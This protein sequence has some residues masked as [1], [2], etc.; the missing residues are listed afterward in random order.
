MF[1]DE[2]IG[3]LNQD[4]VTI[5]YAVDLDLPNGFV[6]THSG[7]GSLVINGF[8]YDGVGSFGSIGEAKSVGD[9]N[10]SSLTV[11]MIGIPSE[12]FVDVLS[13]HIRGSNVE[14]YMIIFDEFGRLDAVESLLFG[15]V[16]SYSLNLDSEGEIAIEVADEFNLYE[17]PLQLFCTN[18][19]WMTDH[20]GDE[21]WR[22]VAQ[23]SQRDIYWGNDIDAERFTV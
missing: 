6:R 10:P 4:G 12:F 3:K 18:E 17:R 22:F 2:F 20:P 7:V 8:T 11:G 5:G 19:S 14:I 15:Q 1:S 21:F 23:L 13:S 16:T 9:A